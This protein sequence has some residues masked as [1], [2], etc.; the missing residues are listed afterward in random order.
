M[1]HGQY[2]F[3]IIIE[4][5]QYV[6]ANYNRDQLSGWYT[7]ILRDEVLAEWHL[8]S[9]DGAIGDAVLHVYC[10][11]SGEEMWPAPPS[12]RSFIFQREMTLVLDTILYA[13]RELLASDP[14]LADAPIYVH[15]RSDLDSL[16]R[17]ME[18]GTLGDKDSWQKAA[19]G[20]VFKQ[21]VIGLFPS[22]DDSDNGSTSSMDQPQPEIETGTA[23]SVTSSADDEDVSTVQEGAPAKAASTAKRFSNNGTSNGSSSS[24]SSII[25]GN[26]MRAPPRTI[27]QNGWGARSSSSDLE[28]LQVLQ[29]V[30]AVLDNNGQR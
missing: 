21:L 7:R 4:Y 24:S 11:V 22:L 27:D 17:I 28:G 12:L 30:E 26:G 13:D 8:Q 16:N 2:R 18:W 20:G 14:R 15:F 5:Y 1:N 3:S 23:V 19:P 10:H 9:A 25:N 6:G 29:P